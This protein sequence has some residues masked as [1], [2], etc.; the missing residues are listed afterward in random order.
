MALFKYFSKVPGNQQYLEK[1]EK[2]HQ[3]QKDALERVQRIRQILGQADVS[4]PVF[5]SLPSDVNRLKKNTSAG[6][7]IEW[8]KETE[9]KMYC[10]NAI[11]SIIE[12][13]EANDPRTTSTQVLEELAGKVEKNVTRTLKQKQTGR[14]YVFT[15]KNKSWKERAI[16]MFFFLNDALGAKD[17]AL[18]SKA[19]DS[20][21]TTISTW[22]NER[23]MWG[24]W[25]PFL[26]ELTVE[27][28]VNSIVNEEVKQIYL[29]SI[30][31]IK[32][33]GLDPHDAQQSAF[34]QHL[35]SLAQEALYNA[36]I[37]GNSALNL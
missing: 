12:D 6:K 31:T 10:K 36:L 24:N 18:T 25:L 35:S 28:V 9:V 21:R 32:K 13:I 1:I 3:L 37:Q 17:M 8:L 16:V 2:E 34:E 19:F 33:C 22:Y 29:D 20:A 5:T 26:K 7:V 23:P 15:N 4:S 30:Q 11:N 14:K 27:E